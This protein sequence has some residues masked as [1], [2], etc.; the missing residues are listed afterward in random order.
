MI[1]LSYYVKT[2]KHVQRQPTGE[3][4]GSFLIWIYL[5]N[6]REIRWWFPLK[7]C[8][9]LSRIL[10]PA[11]VGNHSESGVDTTWYKITNKKTGFQFL[12]KWSRLEFG[13]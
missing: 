3:I 5:R 6:D 10:T 2:R 1:I 4:K 11:V 7:H 8:N 9:E 12:G 13:I